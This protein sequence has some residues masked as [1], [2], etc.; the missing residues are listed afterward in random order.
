MTGWRLSFS[1]QR[2]NQLVYYLA[3]FAPRQR[4]AVGWRIAEPTLRVGP[5]VGRQA[6]VPF[7]NSG[8]A[9]SHAHA[10]FPTDVQ[11]GTLPGRL[12]RLHDS[13]N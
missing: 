2:R 12:L 13:R 11:V 3:S 5:G 8:H 4:R 10:A 6:L 7:C 1:P 9:L